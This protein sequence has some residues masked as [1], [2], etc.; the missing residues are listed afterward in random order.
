M[1]SNSKLGGT[2]IPFNK[3][4]DLPVVKINEL[5]T[6]HRDGSVRY[7]SIGVLDNA[8]KDADV[9]AVVYNGT[10]G[11]TL[12]K[13]VAVDSFRFESHFLKCIMSLRFVL[14]RYVRRSFFAVS[15][16]RLSDAKFLTVGSYKTTWATEL[17]LRAAL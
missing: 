17:G 5:V 11:P 9:V 14:S 3:V 15:V 10:S 8:L 7:F 16:Y 4:S 1:A 13:V 12:P 2:R 6:I